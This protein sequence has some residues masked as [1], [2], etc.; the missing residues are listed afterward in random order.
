MYAE[1]NTKPLPSPPLP[2]YHVDSDDDDNHAKHWL[3]K[4]GERVI[5]SVAAVVH[6]IQGCAHIKMKIIHL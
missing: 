3:V 2:K 4:W 1:A 6:F 5:S